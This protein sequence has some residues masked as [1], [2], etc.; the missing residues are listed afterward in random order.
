M[1]PV[2]V[3]LGNAANSI[4]LIQQELHAYF[5]DVNVITFTD[6]H[7]FRNSQALKNVVAYVLPTDG[8]V[9]DGDEVTTTRDYWKRLA[10]DIYPSRAVKELELVRNAC[11]DGNYWIDGID[12]FQAS[13][14]EPVF[15]F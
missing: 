10:E 9:F 15:A 11:G 3:A 5:G 6:F 12:Q 8:Q 13:T 14:R 1:A 7:S 4:S 2:V